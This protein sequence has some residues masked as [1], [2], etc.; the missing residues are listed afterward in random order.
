MT[1]NLE[2]YRVFYHV[3]C[4]RS[5]SQAAEKMA[6]SQP[7]VSQSMKQLEKTL[8]TK[9]FLRSARGIR[10]TPEGEMLFSY[11]KNGYEEIQRGEQ[12]LDKLKNLE[13]GEITIGA[14][15]MTLRYYLLP[16]LE[17][18]HQLHPAIKIHVTNGPTPETLAYL[19]EGK[20]DFGVVTTPFMQEEWIKVKNV[21]EIEDVFVAGHHYTQLK[22]HM[23]DFQTLLS[24]PVISLESNTSTRR[25]IDSLLAQDEIVL[26][27]E[28]ELATSDMIIQFALR[29]LGIGCVV[30]DFAQP[31]MESG[32]LFAL[33]FNK[34]IPH[35]HM[36]VVTNGQLPVTLAA[37]KMLCLLSEHQ[38]A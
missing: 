25:Y 26:H 35:R 24:Y 20:I 7:A 31:Y 4:C 12:V 3:A 29:N 17:Q 32:K 33:R 14:S 16:Y 2:Y 27:P 34:L 38:N 6:I 28:F 15:D 36:C 30:K 22:N 5:I 13:A 37:E 18:F 10:L 21:R 23:N 11:V 8:G 19:K 1:T 9:L